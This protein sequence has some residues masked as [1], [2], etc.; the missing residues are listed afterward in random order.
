M[1]LEQHLALNNLH[2]EHQSAYIKLYST[3]TALP[4]VQ[5]D[6]LQSLDQSKVTVLVLLDLSAAFDTLDHN[7]LLN[8]L[9]NHFGITGKPLQLM[10]SYVS[11]RYQTVCIDGVQPQGSVLG[12]KLYIMYTNSVGDICRNHRLNHHLY[13]DDSQLYLYFEPTDM[14]S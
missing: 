11:D 4:K 6:I 14:D 7:T 8:R 5:N 13:A 3:E 12:P 1:R 9:K 10:S 2:E